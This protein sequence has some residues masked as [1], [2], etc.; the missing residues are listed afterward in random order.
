MLKFLKRIFSAKN[1][2]SVDEDVLSEENVL[3]GT[4]RNREQ[5][6][7]IISEKFYHIPMQRL[8][9]EPEKIKFVAVYQ[10]AYLY[11]ENAGIY[12]YAAV[13]SFR[14]V[15]RS[16][17]REIPKSGSEPYCYFKL[18]GFKKLKN[19]IRVDSEP[20]IAELTSLYVLRNA[21]TLSELKLK[22]K[23]EFDLS[24]LID[25]CID[26]PDSKFDFGNAVITCSG[27]V[28]SVQCGDADLISLPL[29]A[30]RNNRVDAVRKIL[31]A[32][33]LNGA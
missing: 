12:V 24:R 4:M 32:I 20:I 17:I 10:S 21:S 28:I 29:N 9:C 33:L 6:K 26:N 31:Y 15:K 7:H 14:E 5:L 2:P 25:S 3:V 19:P 1:P 13:D 11:K 16:E 8:P 30:F 27:G 22:N 23:K 18:C